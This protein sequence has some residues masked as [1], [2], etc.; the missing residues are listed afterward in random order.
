[1]GASQRRKGAAFERRVVFDLKEAGFEAKRNL[2]QYQQ[3]DGRDITVDAPFCFQLK[4]GKR[5]NYRQALREA[6]ESC[7]SDYAVAITHEDYGDTVVHM[8]WDDFLELISLPDVLC[9]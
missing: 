1:M 3:S 6:R 5:P 4:T 9:K 2:D 7:G 8:D